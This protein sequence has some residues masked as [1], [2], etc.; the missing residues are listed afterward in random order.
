[1][2]DITREQFEMWRK[3]PETV[4]ILQL[5]EAYQQECMEMMSTGSTLDRQSTDR[6]ALATAELVGKIQGLGFILGIDYRNE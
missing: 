2:I 5:V 4:A 1:M 6:T 3:S